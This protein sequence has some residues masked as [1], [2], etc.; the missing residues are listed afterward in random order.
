MALAYSNITIELKEILLKNR[1]KEL[2]DVSA[3]STVPV[4]CINNTTVIDESLDIMQWAL[5]QHDPENWISNNLEIQLEMIKVSDNDF[6][7]WLDRYKYYDRFPKYNKNY[8]RE[9]CD[10]Y[11]VKLNIQLE[12]NRYLLSNKL[13]LLDIA[14][15]PFVR[16]FANVDINWFND[17][18]QNV[19]RWLNNLIQ[20]DL[21]LSVMDKYLEYQYDQEPLIINFNN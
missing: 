20:S 12:N 4:L 13:L 3:K 1:P 10:E 8:Y 9:K 2:F 17:N 19:S 15:F 7:Y 6:K 16:Q 14:I 5:N 21:Y 18:Y 11:L